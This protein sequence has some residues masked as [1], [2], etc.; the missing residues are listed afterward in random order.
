MRKRNKKEPKSITIHYADPETH[1][2]KHLD[3]QDT[4]IRQHFIFLLQQISIRKAISLI[5]LA[6]F[7]FNCIAIAAG[8]FLYV[9]R[10]NFLF[11]YI[12]ILGIVNALYLKKYN[13][14]QML[15]QIARDRFTEEV[16]IYWKKNIET[17]ESNTT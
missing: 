13:D 11:P 9:T 3:I 5:H 15:T 14:W 1:T 10:F 17:K 7:W 16:Y 12:V 8:L 4:N 2:I 6:I